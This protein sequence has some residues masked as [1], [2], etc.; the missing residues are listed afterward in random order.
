MTGSLSIQQLKSGEVYYVKLSYKDPKTHK[1]KQKMLATGIAVKKG[2]KR[3]AEAKL[4]K[5]LTEYE[6]L[7]ETPVFREDGVDPN[8]TVCDYARVWLDDKKT[9]DISDSTG[10]TYECRMKHVFTYFDEKGTLVKDLTPYIVDRFCKHLLRFGK[11]NQKT[12]AKEPLA[13]RS[14]SDTKVIFAKM[15]DKAVVDG[16][17]ATNPAASVKVGK[18]KKDYT[19]EMYFLSENECHRFLVFLA[20]S[21]DPELKRLAP[22]AFVAIFFGLRRSEILGLKWSAVDFTNK[23]IHIRHTIVR[24]KKLRAKDSTKT[25]N[26]RRSLSL[27]P[28]AEAVFKKVREEQDANKKFF[29][30]TYRNDEGYVFTWEDGH[31]YD[32]S[33]LSDKFKRALAMFGRPELS[34]HKL[35][36]TCASLLIEKGWDPK[37]VQY[38]LGHADIQTTLNIYAHYDRQKMNQSADDLESIVSNVSGLFGE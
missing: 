23:I 2:T 25:K 27:F 37:R 24:I 9:D 10:E 3:K 28:S 15:L 11:T 5:F 18:R 29:G 19:E 7:E 26:S 32:P 31:S 14:V 22:I 35:R 13:P 8:V 16:I 20:N 4:R 38:W 12:G 30:N 21:E 17:I 34:L 6:Y 33:N 1:R 36:H